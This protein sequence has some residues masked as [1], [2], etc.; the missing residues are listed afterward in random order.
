MLHKRTNN[1]NDFNRYYSEENQELLEKKS[2]THPLFSFVILLLMLLGFYF[3]YNYFVTMDIIKTD[4]LVSIQ[5]EVPL[6]KEK[7]VVNK[8]VE[9]SINTKKIVMHKKKEAL[10]KEEIIIHSEQNNTLQIITKIKDE[11]IKIKKKEHLVKPHIEVKKQLNPINVNEVKP[12]KIDIPKSKNSSHKISRKKHY[13]KNN[14]YNK[15]LINTQ[16][17]DKLS[18]ELYEVINSM[19]IPEK[20]TNIE[21]F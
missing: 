8:E 11:L 9:K 1:F 10:P 2:K 4:E 5:K 20:T 14:H 3:T 16:N 21:K 7:I 15:V 6:P 13:K 19:P 17:L 12:I 18:S